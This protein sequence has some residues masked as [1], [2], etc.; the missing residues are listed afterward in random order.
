MKNNLIL[1]K[2]LLIGDSITQMG[3]NPDINGWV[4][5]VENAWIRK[6][7]VMNRGLSGYNTKWWLPILEDIL[8]IAQHPRGCEISLA[9]LFLG[10]NDVAQ[11]DTQYVPLEAYEKNLEIM[12]TQI[13]RHC[14]RIVVVCPPPV[15]EA[16]WPDRQLV[17]AKEYRNAAI[18]VAKRFSASQVQVLDTWTAFLGPNL[19]VDQET[20]DTLLSDGLHLSS[21]GNGVLYEKFYALVLK[22]WPEL[23][24]ESM[25]M[26]PKDW[27]EYT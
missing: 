14:K 22:Q 8:E 23:T 13:S 15:D 21:K 6:L 10:A 9:T 2:I 25:A 17:R 1:D 4:A 20:L 3:C 18:A 12:V 24:P 5:A 27:K 7:E 16:K 26:I 11:N 19:A